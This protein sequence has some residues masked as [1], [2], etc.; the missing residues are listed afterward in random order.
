MSVRQKPTTFYEAADRIV[1]MINQ[2]HI[3]N[4]N[5]TLDAIHTSVANEC[6]LQAKGLVIDYDDGILTATYGG[7]LAELSIPLSRYLLNFPKTLSVQHA[8]THAVDEFNTLFIDTSNITH[9]TEFK[10]MAH[11][12]GE[13][14]HFYLGNSVACY[15]TLLDYFAVVRENTQVAG[16]KNIY[17][18]TRAQAIALVENSITLPYQAF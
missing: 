3:F 9:F 8:L 12:L 14:S 16:A 11:P 4:L 17:Y 1:S 18:L 7:G 15:F 2:P 6:P 10:Y 13:T 5:D